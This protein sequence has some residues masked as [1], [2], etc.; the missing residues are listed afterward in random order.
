MKFVKDAGQSWR[1][2]SMQAMGAVAALQ[3]VW[4]NL[5]LDLK[6]KVNPEWIPY[7]TIAVAISGVVGRLMPQGGDDA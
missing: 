2:F 7:I 4:I 6:S 5:P 3:V 1:W